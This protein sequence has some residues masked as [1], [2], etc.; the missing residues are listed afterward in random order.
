MSSF[1]SLL[2]FC[3]VVLSMEEG[4]IEILNCNCGFVYFLFQIYQFW[5]HFFF[6]DACP[7]TT[8]VFSW[9]NDTFVF[10]QCPS[11]SLVSLFSLKYTLSGIFIWYSY[12][13]G[14]EGVNRSS[15][16]PASCCW[17]LRW[18]S[19][20]LMGGDGSCRPHVVSTDLVAGWGGL[21][22]G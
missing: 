4:I 16:S 15:G 22:A 18:G 3:L 10:I 17:H 20:L 11:W 8:A 7:F 2:L 1:I 14:N 13:W 6:F 19:L 12:S 21:V 5:L 9:W